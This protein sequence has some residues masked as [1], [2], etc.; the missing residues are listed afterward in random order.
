MIKKVGDLPLL[1]LKVSNKNYLIDCGALCQKQNFYNNI[2][3]I[4]IPEM[5]KHTG[6]TNVDTLVL[7]KPSKRLAKVAMQFA[8]QTDV[9]TIIAT[10]KNDCFKTLAVAYKHSNV[11]VLPLNSNVKKLCSR[12]NLEHSFFTC[13]SQFLPLK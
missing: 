4:I 6:I 2:D 1:A 8:K 12:K 11:K 9:K 10:T 7:C 3:Y 5:I 13:I